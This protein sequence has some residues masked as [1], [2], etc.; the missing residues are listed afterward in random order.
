[1][2]LLKEEITVDLGGRPLEAL[3]VVDAR[4]PTP[5]F[6]AV[7]PG[8]G[9]HSAL[10]VNEAVGCA[11]V[12]LVSSSSLSSPLTTI[13]FST[14]VTSQKRI[15]LSDPPVM[16]KPYFDSRLSSWLSV[17]AIMARMPRSELLDPLGSRAVTKRP[18]IP[19]GLLQLA[20][21][22]S[23]SGHL[24][25]HLYG[26]LLYVQG[27]LNVPYCDTPL[28]HYLLQHKPIYRGL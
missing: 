7:G 17:P 1:M 8:R 19:S 26:R 3:L 15:F 5:A 27:L 6:G 13:E 28:D 4:E 24:D 10:R 11:V 18:N 14:L 23:L 9:I 12:G 21:G 2:L 16:M 20:T 22:R 25:Y